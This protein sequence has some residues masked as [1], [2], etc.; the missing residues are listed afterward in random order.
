MISKEEYGNAMWKV[1]HSYTS[2]LP[3]RLNRTDKIK[4]RQ[5]LHDL[6]EHYPCEDCQ[7]HAFSYIK[8][9]KPNFNT[10]KDA[11]TWTCDFHN[12]VNESL[13]KPREDCHTLW[14][15]RENCDSC[16]VEKK[17]DSGKTDK[18][19]STEQDHIPPIQSDMH[20]QLPPNEISNPNGS[21]IQTYNYKKAA[22]NVNQ[23]LEHSL[24]PSFESYKKVTTEIV[25]RMCKNAG[26]P[27]P[28]LMFSDQTLCKDPN[29][30]CAQIPV[31]KNGIIAKNVPSRLLFNYN[32]FSPRSAVHETMHYILKFK[33]LDSLA[34]NE[35]EISR[36]SRQLIA[37]D[38]PS[39]PMKLGQRTERSPTKVMELNDE[40]SKEPF[41]VFS[42]K[43]IRSRG[44]TRLANMDL[45][46]FSRYYGPN[47]KHKGEAPNP[48]VQPTVTYSNGEPAF[49]AVATQAPEEEQKQSE[50][51]FLSMLDPIY[52]PFADIL[53]MKAADVNVAH[54]PA[55]IANAGIVL[56]ESNLNSFG[57]MISSIIA[58]G[59]TLAAGTLTKDSLSYM[60]K[61]LLV[62]LGGAL[63]WSGVLRYIVNPKK[64]GEVIEE[65]TSF[66]HSIHEMDVDAMVASVTHQDGKKIEEKEP[67]GHVREVGPY[68]NLSSR[69]GGDE[70]PVR[71]YERRGSGGLTGD[72]YGDPDIV[73]SANGVIGSGSPGSFAGFK[74]PPFF[75]SM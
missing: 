49:P 37:R 58:S 61:R 32:Q 20:S 11:F 27:I 2:N 57:S 45:P 17:H 36:Q 39:E 52:A 16:S 33:G 55:L 29:S 54:T 70:I 10:N 46:Y 4:F 1:I 19:T 41:D 40:G 23:F 64:M 60:D 12:A 7:K 21:E 18:E 47:K 62:G 71:S 14:N 3:E 53:G 15:G 72:I 22:V 51:G 59:M 38:F 73:D 26:V 42:W 8:D 35:E 25:E 75:P 74:R 56:A 31:Q 66:G 63:L 24:K 48:A 13:G 9:H 43:Q 5:T 68:R 69:V 67:L 34:G 28:E 44:K 50:S 65:A 6:V 30:S